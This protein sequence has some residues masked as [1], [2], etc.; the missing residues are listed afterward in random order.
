MTNLRRR[1]APDHRGGAG[2]PSEL[3]QFKYP[4]LT[5]VV[6]ETS[7]H[8]APD[9]PARVFHVVA[10]A[11]GNG[12]EYTY[13]TLAA[14]E[15][16]SL[17]Q[18]YFTEFLRRLAD[19][20]LLSA[21]RSVLGAFVS[22][23]WPSAISLAY[24]L[25]DISVEA[26]ERPQD[27][28]S[29]ETAYESCGSA[30]G[31]CRDSAP[32]EGI[33]A[34]R[35]AQPLHV[36]DPALAGLAQPA[37]SGHRAQDAGPGQRRG[38]RREFEGDAVPRTVQD[39]GQVEPPV[40]RGADLDTPV[41]TTRRPAREPIVPVTPSLLP[42]CSPCPPGCPGTAARRIGVSPGLG[43]QSRPPRWVH[44]GNPRR[45]ARGRGETLRPA[46]NS[47]QPDTEVRL[48]A[49]TRDFRGRRRRGGR[50]GRVPPGQ[51]VTRASRCSPRGRLRRPRSTDVDFTI[52]GRRRGPSPGRG[53]SSGAAARDDHRRH[54]LRHQVVEARHGLER[55]LARHAARRCGDWRPG[56]SLAFC[57]GGYTDESAARR[58]HRRAR[59]GS[60]TS[61]AASR[62]SPSTAAR[63]GCS[64]RTSTSGRAPS[65]C[66]ASSCARGRARLLGALRIPQL[67][68]PWQE[69][70]YAGD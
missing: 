58:P 28:S 26:R 54:P 27:R 9:S 50:P 1:P 23:G 19:D 32:T 47:E 21:V 40:L 42:D 56:T 2:R 33:N 38:V 61:T 7:A 68:D 49:L 53:T 35:R 36:Q 34:L 3:A 22:V 55:R 37:R 45:E 13:D 31:E 6:V 63:P 14:D 48:M 11:V 62:S 70:R 64:C 60:P 18:R 15:T 39:D 67:R 44:P 29:R 5:H 12:D 20:D 24:R 66:A 8:L 10:A 51:Y 59:P 17:V 43:P 30:A 57:D 65:G 16:I 4:A 69:Q 52:R 41:T 46:W 25:S